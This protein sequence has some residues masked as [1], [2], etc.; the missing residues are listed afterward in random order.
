MDDVTEKWKQ[1]GLF[2]N[3]SHERIE[4]IA[5]TLDN[6]MKDVIAGNKPYLAIEEEIIR[7][8]KDGAFL[9]EKKVEESS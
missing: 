4:V 5:S 9:T 2:D 7:L 1:T 6:V 3:L 8:R